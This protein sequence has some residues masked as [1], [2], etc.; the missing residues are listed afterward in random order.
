MESIACMYVGPFCTT[1][2]AN[3]KRPSSEATTLGGERGGR[4]A[5]RSASA[6][7]N[8]S[9]ISFKSPSLLLR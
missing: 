6:H 2:E 3:T 9:S 5:R 8:H 1:C 4:P 7:A